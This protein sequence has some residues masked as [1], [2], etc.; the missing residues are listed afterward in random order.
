MPQS[1]PERGKHTASQALSRR[2]Q[3]TVAYNAW[4]SMN[5]DPNRSSG[6]RTNRRS[7]HA[8]LQVSDARGQNSVEPGRNVVD[9]APDFADM[10]GRPFPC[11]CST[12]ITHTLNSVQR[13]PALRYRCRSLAERNLNLADAAVGN[14]S[15]RPRT[16]L[17]RE[18]LST[19]KT[20]GCKPA[21]KGRTL[22]STAVHG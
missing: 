6:Q 11:L 8:D 20:K 5:K 17:G 19:L 18:H 16:K 21:R 15:R 7:R 10:L 2:T 22:V 1:A 14:N 13:N 4:W 9:P 12:A 3:S